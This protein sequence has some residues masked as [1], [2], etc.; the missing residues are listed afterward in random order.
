MERQN[1]D[2]QKEN[3]KLKDDNRR[4]DTS[5][6]YVHKLEKEN[7][8][9]KIQFED[10]ERE[11]TDREERILSLKSDLLITKESLAQSLD[12]LHS[13]Q[14]RN[15]QLQSAYDSAAHDITKANE[16]ISKLQADM[17][18]IKTRLKSKSAELDVRDKDYH[19]LE[20]N[21][22]QLSEKEAKI[23]ELNIQLD[24]KTRELLSAQETLI[25]H[26]KSKAITSISY[27]ISSSTTA[28]TASFICTF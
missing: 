8:R 24:L 9:L 20:K 28:R 4:Y 16:I 23:S 12:T 26:E 19:E 6:D 5:G 15:N 18:T 17:K 25:K 7:S 1:Q 11:K 21:L 2:I 22:H 10:A 13:Q 3:T 14:Q 27:R